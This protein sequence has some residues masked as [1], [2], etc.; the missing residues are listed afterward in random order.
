MIIK[1]QKKETIQKK[2]QRIFSSKYFSISS[3]N[4]IESYS[5]LIGSVT[6][7]LDIGVIFTVY[8]L[9]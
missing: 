9:L 7:Q 3:G 6:F 5:V 4:H 8:R 2:L 1:I